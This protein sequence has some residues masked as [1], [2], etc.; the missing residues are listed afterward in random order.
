MT[1][2]GRE[3]IMGVDSARPVFQE[4]GIEPSIERQQG[5][6]EGGGRW[7]VAIV[8]ADVSEAN[9][10]APVDDEDGRAGNLPALGFVLMTDAVAVDDAEAGIGQDRVR[11]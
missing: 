1:S 9:D 8:L 4:V 5:Q 11:E 6:Q 2:E 7:S 10:P 3:R